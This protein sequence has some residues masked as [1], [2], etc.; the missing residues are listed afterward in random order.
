MGSLSQTECNK[1]L[2]NLIKSIEDMETENRRYHLQLERKKKRSQPIQDLLE[3]DPE[4]EEDS[5][6][7]AEEIEEK[8]VDQLRGKDINKVSEKEMDEEILLNQ[9]ESRVLKALREKALLQRSSNELMCQLQGLQKEHEL[10]IKEKSELIRNY[11]LKE[12]V[13]FFKKKQPKT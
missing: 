1:I 7:N 9:I 13:R 3:Y 2:E 5:V 11:E 6:N 4:D 12:K 10:E 8:E